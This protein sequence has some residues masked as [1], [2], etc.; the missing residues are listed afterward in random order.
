MREERRLI[1]EI[2]STSEKLPWVVAGGRGDRDLEVE[3]ELWPD[4]TGRMGI[5]TVRES[6]REERFWDGQAVG[7]MA[8][9]CL[10]GLAVSESDVAGTMGLGPALEEGGMGADF[11]QGLVFCL[12]R[13]GLKEEDVDAA[14]RPGDEVR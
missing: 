1:V 3:R 11:S 4:L 5:W 12:R 8:L 2:G 10:R 6:L 14:R 7:G 13:E 9:D